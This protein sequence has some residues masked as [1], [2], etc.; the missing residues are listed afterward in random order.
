MFPRKSIHR[1]F[2]RISFKI[3]VE[4]KGTL[5]YIYIVLDQIKTWFNID[6]RILETK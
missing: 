5:I 2:S 4:T 1:V 6:K 3:F